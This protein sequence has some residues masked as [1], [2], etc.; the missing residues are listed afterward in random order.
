MTT[1]LRIYPPRRSAPRFWVPAGFQR[2]PKGAIPAGADF[3]L[4][5][6][7]R[8]DGIIPQNVSKGASFQVIAEVPDGA[9]IPLLWLYEYQPEFQHAF[10]FRKPITLPAKTKLHGVPSGSSIL[11][12][13]TR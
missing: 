2:T 7:F 5:R 3:V 10:H 4:P 1:T 6:Q 12:L 8:L 11:L 9:V 13:P